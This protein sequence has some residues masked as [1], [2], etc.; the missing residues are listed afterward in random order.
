MK[1][2]N[3]LMAVLLLLLLTACGQQKHAVGAIEQKT[4]D[5]P[6]PSEA[7]E[8]KEEAVPTAAQPDRPETADLKFV[9]EGVE[10]TVPAVLYLGQGYSIY[11]PDKGWRL[12]DRERDDSVLEVTWESTHRDDVELQVLELG[13]RTL[14]EAQAFVKAE[15]DDFRFQEDQ[16]GGLLGT[17]ERDRE[18]MEVRFHSGEHGMYA[19]VYI[20]PE[21]AAEEFGTRLSVMAD[22]FALTD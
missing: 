18:I 21:K 14:A 13:N 3:L 22:T 16:Q 19:V 1:K 10:E 15:E 5:P 9:L 20:Y 17:D 8:L 7:A 11:I 12:D 4:K 6:V 2:R